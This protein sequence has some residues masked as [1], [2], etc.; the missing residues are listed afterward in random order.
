MKPENIIFSRGDAFVLLLFFGIVLWIGAKYFKKPGKVVDFLLGGRALTLPIF[1]LTLFSTWYGGILGIGEFGF[2]YGISSW[3]IQGVP[4]YIFAAVFALVFAKRARRAEV[5]TIPDQLFK[6]YGR[7]VSL[8]GAAFTGVLS[9]PAPYVLMIAVLLQIVTG[10]ALL[11][12]LIIGVA[13]TISYLWFGGF[14]ADVAVDIFFGVLM[15]IGFVIILPFL[16]AKFGGV[17]FLQANLPPLHTKWH[18]GN[19]AQFIIMWFFIALWTFIEPTFY[20]RCYAAKSESV[21]VKGVLISIFFWFIFDV[22]TITA[23]LYSKAI[24][25]DLDQPMMAYPLLAQLVLPTFWKGLFFAGMFATILSTLN[26]FLFVSATTLGRDLFWKWN[27]ENKKT[28]ISWIQ[29]GM[30]I[31]GILCIWMAYA[32]PSV[33]KLWY[34]IGT[35][36][37]PGLLIAM[38]STFFPKMQVSSRWMMAVMLSGFLVSLLCLG[39][40]WRN[41]IG[42]Y[43]FP[44]GIEPMFPG[45]GASIL[46]WLLGQWQR[47]IKSAH[48]RK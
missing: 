22:M 20:Q 25:Q 39:Y 40:G 47:S 38:V 31:S 27:G 16:Y 41:Q 34:S 17:A 5:V 1:V 45:L 30:V 6:T 28:E 23:A 48:V 29:A 11:P 43:E 13:F 7:N 37:V 35:V 3:V 18:G 44:F 15:M 14:K 8:L 32:I 2:T 9:C 19:S 26:S 33:V 42:G 24:F 4:Y 21:A 36:I 46:I 10:W 12:C